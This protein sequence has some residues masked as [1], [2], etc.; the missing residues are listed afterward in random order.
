[1]T[2]DKQNPKLTPLRA[3]RKFLIS[4]DIK[5]DHEPPIYYAWQS[6]RQPK[7]YQDDNGNIFTSEPYITIDYD[8]SKREWY[9]G[10]IIDVDH[11]YFATIDDVTGRCDLISHD[12]T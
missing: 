5:P 8:K 9:I 7:W 4:Y 11:R 10:Y 3:I 2:R 12:L 6:K 1:M